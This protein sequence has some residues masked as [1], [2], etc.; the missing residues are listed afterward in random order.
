MSAAVNYLLL[1]PR[2]VG[3][4][5]FNNGYLCPGHA[6]SMDDFMYKELH[7]GWFVLSRWNG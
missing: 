1:P 2:S 3:A 4:S 5:S 7:C 6:A